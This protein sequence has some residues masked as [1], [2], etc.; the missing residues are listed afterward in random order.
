MA[1]QGEGGHTSKWLLLVILLLVGAVVFASC[2]MKPLPRATPQP[3]FSTNVDSTSRAAILAYADTLAFTDSFAAGETRRLMRGACPGSCSYGP[4]VRLEPETG[5][6]AL[7]SAA[8]WQGRI[9]ARLVN[10]SLGPAD[11]YPKFNLTPGG[12]SYWWV[13]GRGGA[14]RSLFISRDTTRAFEPDSFVLHVD[15]NHYHWKA[16]VAKYIWTEVDEELWVACSQ[17]CCKSSGGSP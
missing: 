5:S 11:S 4:L 10:L 16:S 7:D 13:D 15:A 14:W 6:V 1:S 17:S 2:F 12:T 8:L 3:P 9:I